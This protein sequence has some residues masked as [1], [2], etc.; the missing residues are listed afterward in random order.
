MV[1][2]EPNA[3]MIIKELAHTA[4]ILIDANVLRV[5]ACGI[6]ERL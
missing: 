4:M 2:A 1:T 6:E 5:D 3:V